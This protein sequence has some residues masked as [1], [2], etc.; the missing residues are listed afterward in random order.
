MYQSIFVDKKSETIFLW[1]DKAGL[2]TMPVAQATYA[3]RRQPGGKYKSLYGDELEKIKNFSPRD[4]SLF[5]SDVPLTTRVLI[6]AYEDSDEPSIGHRIVFLDIETDVS[7]GFST[8]MEA[9]NKITAISIYDDVSKKYV[10]YIL[11]EDNRLPDITNKDEAVIISCE[12]EESLLSKFLTKIEEIRPTIITGW[13]ICQYD[14]PYIVNRITKVL[15]KI[16]TLRLSPISIAYINKG[17]EEAV[18]AGV[19]LLDYMILYQKFI[20]RNEPSYALG[21]IGKKVVKMEKISYTGNLNTLYESDINKY[22][23]YNLNDVKIVVALDAKLKFIDLARN[24]CHTG[25]VPYEY[26]GMSS[27]YIEGAMLIYLR[28]NGLVAPNKSLEGREEYESRLEESEEGFEGAFVKDPI[29]G[30]YDWVYDL[31]LTSMYP[32]IMISLNISPETVVSKVDGW[33]IEK[34]LKNEYQVIKIGGTDY[35]IDDF[36]KMMSENKFSIASNGVIY[37]ME[38]TGL[39]PSILIKWFDERKNLRKLAK[40]YA[41][42]GDTEKYEFYDGR[43]K[44]QKILLNSAYGVLGLE[45][46]RFYNKNNAEAV[47]I[48]GQDIIKT[49][50]KAINKYYHQILGESDKDYVVYVDTDSAFASAV[51]IIEHTMPDVDL[52]DEKKMS[53]SILKV[54]SDVQ[55]FVNK[56]YDLMAKKFFNIEKHRFDIKQEVI[57]KSSFWLAKKRYCQLI[58]NKA[59][60]PC[61]ELEV[62]GIDVVR[63]SFPAVFR[64]FMNQFLIDVLKKIPQEEID[65]KIIQFLESINSLD[66]VDLAKNTSVKFVSQDKTKDYNPKCRKPFQTIKGTPAQVKA[67]LMYN[68][69]I[70][71][72]NLNKHVQ[73]I[74]DGQKIKWVYIKENSFGIEALAMKADGTDPKEIVKFLTDYIDRNSMYEQELKSKLEDFY[75]ILKWSYPTL[76]GKKAKEF[77]D[78]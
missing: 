39:I 12:N 30:R 31:D 32:N 2:I 63:T 21:V 28:R 56:F 6:D 46:F 52:N 55:S 34:Y 48:T 62:K 4:P 50:N 20:G 59:G 58:I 49:T 18:V 76:E 78:F 35:P 47:T 26:F 3:Y 33:N 72:F 27:R 24:I 37:N 38:K 61:D 5:E 7:N 41:E 74:F 9:N 57:S 11:D 42:E 65:K 77:F 13:N 19:S 71:Y 15:G 16:N 66:I 17:S 53:E 68:D 40:K 64:K 60:I 54:A 70:D 36:K 1:D 67:A 75:S 23:D 14:M 69:L 45:V 8:P 44:V 10:A 43:Q 51:P 29:P 22:I 73:P 25:H